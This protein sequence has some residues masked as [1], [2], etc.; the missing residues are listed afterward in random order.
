MSGSYRHTAGGPLHD[1]SRYSS[2]QARHEVYVDGEIASASFWKYEDL[3][4]TNAFCAAARR[5]AL[6]KP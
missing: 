3:I 5:S 1:A 2:G 4:I 6:I